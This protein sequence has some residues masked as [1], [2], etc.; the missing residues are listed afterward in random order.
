MARNR[1]KDYVEKL[2]NNIEQKLNMT[3]SQISNLTDSEFRL[4]LQHG[5]FSKKK[6]SNDIQT[7]PTQRQLNVLNL[8]YGRKEAKIVKKVKPI[9]VEGLVTYQKYYLKY[10]K[11]I[12]VTINRDNRFFNIPKI[13]HKEHYPLEVRQNIKGRYIDAKTGRFISTKK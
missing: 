12:P 13:T 11:A 5:Y 7:E 3:S 1:Y 4:L 6:Y 2:A 9:K 8:H 10:H